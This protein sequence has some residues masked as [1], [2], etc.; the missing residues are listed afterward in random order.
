MRYIEDGPSSQPFT[1]ASA[2]SQCFK[3]VLQASAEK[4]KITKVLLNPIKG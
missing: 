3:L 2:S 4:N 1:S